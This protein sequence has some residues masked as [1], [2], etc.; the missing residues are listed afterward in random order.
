M[1]KHSTTEP[2]GTGRQRGGRHVAVLSRRA[3]VT[4]TGT[5]L[6]AAGG[7][8]ATSVALEGTSADAE[9]T[10]APPAPTGTA[11]AVTAAAAATVGRPLANSAWQIHFGNRLTEWDAAWVSWLLRGTGAPKTTGVA[12]L[13]SWA[14]QHG[15][16]DGTP[17]PGALIFYF[18]PHVVA[19]VHVGLVE[20]VTRGV[21]QTIEGGSPAN[22]DP[23]H[24]FVRR[25]SAPW[26]T[27]VRFGHVLPV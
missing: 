19:P 15:T 4:A 27:T 22:L 21:A 12:A 2:D 25:F 11:A 8:V 6:V 17:K 3:F 24:Q 16:V 5:L 23:A 18:A 13:H 1:A 9:Q 26:S 10:P 7:I 20:S 14:Q